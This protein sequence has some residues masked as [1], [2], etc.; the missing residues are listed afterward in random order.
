MKYLLTTLLTIVLAA[1]ILIGVSRL[2]LGPSANCTESSDSVKWARSLSQDRLSKLHRQMVV[3]ERSDESY[4][5]VELESDR[6]PNELSDLI[7]HDILIDSH[8]ARLMLEGCF[9]HYVI[10]SFAGVVDDNPPA[11]NLMWGE[12]NETGSEQLWPM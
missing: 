4:N 6:S 8:R 5:R 9:D 2:I 11:V 12:H 3:L 7:Y 10:M 1:V